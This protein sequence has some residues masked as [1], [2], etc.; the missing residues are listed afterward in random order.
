MEHLA[1]TETTVE[2]RVDRR[3]QEA[4]GLVDERPA[5]AWLR[6]RIKPSSCSVTPNCRTVWPTGI[7]ASAHE[8]TLL[9]TAARLLI[10]GIAGRRVAA[11]C[12]RYG[13][14]DDC[15]PGWTVDDPTQADTLTTELL[16]AR[17]AP[18]DQSTH[19]SAHLAAFDELESWSVSPS[20]A[21]S[22]PFGLLNAT[23]SLGNQGEWLRA[24]IPPVQ[25][26]L[27][28]AI[29]HHASN[30]GRSKPIRRQCRR[31]AQADFLPGRRQPTKRDDC[32]SSRP[33][34]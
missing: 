8:R 17:S 27:R 19:A 12:W 33:R 3:V 10:D 9:A 24:A 23:L 22:P 11:R 29:E 4:R 31:V 26:T 28:S 7:F 21:T 34:R 6:S 30:A 5:Q 18:P 20:R 13:S 1:D 16:A 14:Q 25:Q 15:Q 2:E 32:G